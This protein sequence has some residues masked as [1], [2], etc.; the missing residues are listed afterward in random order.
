MALAALVLPS[1]SGGENVNLDLK[2]V[3][4]EREEGEGGVRGGRRGSK[5]KPRDSET[6]QCAGQ[7]L[8]PGLVGRGRIDPRVFPLSR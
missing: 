6:K 1:F 2:L 5:S 7:R 8:F 4:L 3:A